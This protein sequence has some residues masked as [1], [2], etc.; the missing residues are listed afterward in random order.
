MFVKENTQSLIIQDCLEVDTEE[1]NDY[2]FEPDCS[3]DVHAI[4]MDHV[5]TCDESEQN[6]REANYDFDQI[7]PPVVKPIWTN[8]KVFQRIIRPMA[9]EMNH[10]D[11]RWRRDAITRMNLAMQSY[12]S[13]QLKNA[14]NG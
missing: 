8:E 6:S 2:D 1:E 11:L 3:F 5:S 10:S 4:D 9:L 14:S 12:L 13:Y 7:Y